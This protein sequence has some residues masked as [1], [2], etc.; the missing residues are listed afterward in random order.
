[1]EGSEVAEER[2]VEAIEVDVAVVGAGPAGIAAACAA[3]RVVTDG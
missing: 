2:G 1:M 3:A